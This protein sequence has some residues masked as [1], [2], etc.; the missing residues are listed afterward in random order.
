[1]SLKGGGLDKGGHRRVFIVVVVFSVVIVLSK[2]PRIGEEGSSKWKLNILI[3]FLSSKKYFKIGFSANYAAKRQ[4]WPWEG[5]N[6]IEGNFW[7]ASRFKRT[8]MLCFQVLSL[9]GH[10][11]VS[12]HKAIM[13]CFAI[14]PQCHTPAYPFLKCTW[15]IHKRLMYTIIF[16][17]I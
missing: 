7:I 8:E 9:S 13:P 11:V 2:C 3:A 10:N 16:S 6:D 1:M 4:F 15:S 14:G 17:F 5:Q 12:W